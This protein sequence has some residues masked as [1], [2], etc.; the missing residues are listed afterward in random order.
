MADDPK[1][2]LYKAAARLNLDAHLRIS[3]KKIE[4]ML[5]FSAPVT[6]ESALEETILY[7]SRIE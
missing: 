3:T 2:D 4:S 7:L 1:T 6:W 5:K